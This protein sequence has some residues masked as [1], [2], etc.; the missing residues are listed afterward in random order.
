MPTGGIFGTSAT[1][2]FCGA[3]ERGSAG[4]TA[5]LRDPG[6]TVLT[7]AILIVLLVWLATRTR[8]RPAAPLRLAHRR[9][10]GQVLT[11][12][13]R[14]YWRRAPVFLGIGLV[15]IPLGIAISIV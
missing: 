12:S 6:A 4:L 1:D 5:L 14:M 8:W 13:G 2:F 3:V 10:W 11:A 15:F 9:R 7:I